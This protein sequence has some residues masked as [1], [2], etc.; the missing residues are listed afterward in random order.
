MGRWA[1]KSYKLTNNSKFMNLKDMWKSLPYFIKG[2]LIGF[3]GIAIYSSIM[4]SIIVNNGISV[5]DQ[6][7]SSL[8]MMLLMGEYFPSSLI[9]CLILY[10]VIGLL[11]G[12]IV[13]MVK[14]IK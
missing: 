10:S 11:I 9:F 2:G 14:K 12:F 5:N 1:R 4:Y 13:G 7:F 3:V 6:F 8:P